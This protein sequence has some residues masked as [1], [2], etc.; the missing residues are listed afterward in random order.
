M[1]FIG[2]TDHG[3]GHAKVVSERAEYLAKACK[4]PK[5]EQ[6]LARIAGWC[7]DM[8]NFMGRTQHHYWGAILF[9]Q[10]MQSK[11][12]PGELT[13]VMQ[14][15]AN[16]DKED[17]TIPSALTACVVIADKSDVR[18]NRV[19]DKTKKNLGQD[20]HDRVNHAVTSNQLKVDLKKKTIT[21]LL[22]IDTRRSSIE[23]YFEIFA[24]R[25]SY[26][27]HAA[28]VLGCKFGIVVN[29]VQVL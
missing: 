17:I 3:F 19:F 2:F 11:I 28:E 6:E 26:C 4:L 18:R 23:E 7:H 10:A 8:G 29:K 15:I 1:K 12:N 9:G 14:A 24:E 13:A 21:L 5:R 27:R 20:I 16:H 22:K 25:M